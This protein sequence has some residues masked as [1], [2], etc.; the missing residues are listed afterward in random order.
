MNKK[1]PLILYKG[2]SLSTEKYAFEDSFEGEIEIKLDLNLILLAEK[3]FRLFTRYTSSSLI[4]TLSKEEFLTISL[5][6]IGLPKLDF[7]E[8]KNSISGIA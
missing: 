1:S 2:F 6:F 4:F 8:S 3:F 5:E 7:E